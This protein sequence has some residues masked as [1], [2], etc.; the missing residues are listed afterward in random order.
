M[1]GT[2]FIELSSC[3]IVTVIELLSID[4]MVQHGH[5]DLIIITNITALSLHMGMMHILCF[6]AEKYTTQIFQTSPLIYC[7]LLWYKLL[8]HQQRSMILSIRRAQKQFRLTGFGIFDVSLETYLK[9]ME[10]YT[11]VLNA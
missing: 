3:V 5:G 10:L 2:L 11:T 1:S 8:I 6:F 7:D 9:V 4:Y